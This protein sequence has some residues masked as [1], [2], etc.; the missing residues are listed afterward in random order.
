M[1]GIDELAASIATHGLMQ[2]VVVRRLA[3]GYQLVAGH[4][5]YEAVCSLGWTEIP[6]VVRD[7]TEEAA[8]ILTLV[9]NLQRED[10][11]ADEEAQALGV[12]IRERGWSVRKV[13]ES[14]N[15]DH[16]YVSRRL[17]VFEDAVLR[18]SV[19]TEQLPVSTA[20]VLLRVKDEE[21]R[22]TLLREAIGQGWG[23]MDVRRAVRE[24]GVTP[25]SAASL[26][27]KAGEGSSEPQ[28]GLAHRM[29][30]LREELCGLTG[31]RLSS[32][33]RREAATLLDVLR[34]LVDEQAAPPDR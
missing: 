4:R 2:P 20:E 9:E 15:R 7:E 34:S 3:E 21:H 8:Y 25:H 27:A 26:Q 17:R 18:E 33:Q 32:G 30:S 29:Q 24:W 28:P 31:V 10:L 6:A 23:Q 11:T 13:A 12:L 19:L 16:L 5:R 1:A 22:S 14:I